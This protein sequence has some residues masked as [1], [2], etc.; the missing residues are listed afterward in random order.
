LTT[1][2]RDPIVWVI[3]DVVTSGIARIVAY[4]LLD[5]DLVTHDHAEGAI[6]AELS[7]IYARLG[8][9]VAPPDPGRLKGRH[10][11]AAR[12]IVTIVT[13]GIYSLWWLYDVMV[14]GNRYFEH[15][16]KWEDGLAAS[17]QSL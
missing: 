1:Q 8:A 3:L 13:C 10:N 15:N 2:F 5:G 6:E 12:V 4:C 17:V 7:A 11:Y 14:E 16:W 9:P